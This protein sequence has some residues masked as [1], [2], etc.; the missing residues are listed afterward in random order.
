MAS[1]DVSFLDQGRVVSCRVEAPEPQAVAALLGVPAA[2]LLSVGLVN[3]EANSTSSWSGGQFPLRLF[4]QEMAVLLAAGIPMLEA[5]VT[6]LEKESSGRVTA[7][8]D[9]LAASLQH[10]ESFSASAAKQPAAFDP[11]FVA[12]IAAAERS[13]QL[14]VA[15]RAHAAYLQWVEALRH[16]LIGASVY[17]LLLVGSSGAVMLFLLMFVVPRF[18]GVLEGVGGDMPAGSRWLLRVGQLFGDHPGWVLAVVAALLL[19]LMSTVRSPAARALVARCAWS[20]P[21]L[22]DRLRLLALARLFRTLGML[23]E[24]GV[25]AV[26]AL[27]TARSVVAPSMRVA[28]DGATQAVSGGMSLSTAFDA[29]DL[30]TPVSSRM[31]R[32]GERSGA[33]GPMLTQ[34]AEFYDEELVRLGELVTRLVNPLLMLLMG[35]LIGLI[36]VLLY[37]PIFQLAEQVS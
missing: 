12:V 28:L 8:L 14:G 29:A 5:V 21:V 9:Q 34:A 31:L 10:G 4:S 7:V 20:L 15:L 30:A 23:L 37:M 16:K 11:L 24:A 3:T 19:A 17:P 22:G 18:A 2:H 26:A 35:G 32:V 27:K 1:F 25:P 33:L 36:V 13:G 6:L